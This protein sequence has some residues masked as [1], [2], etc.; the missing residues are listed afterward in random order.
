MAET[1]RLET[2]LKQIPLNQRWRIQDRKRLERA[3]QGQQ[4]VLLNLRHRHQRELLAAMEMEES[5][6]SGGKADRS[7]HLNE[8]AWRGSAPA[9]ANKI[10]YT[11]CTD[12]GKVLEKM[13]DASVMICP[14][15]GTS[16]R[17]LPT[18]REGLAFNEDVE[19]VNSYQKKNHLQELLNSVQGRETAPIPKNV[20]EDIQSELYKQGIVCSKDITRNKLYD[21]LKK[22]KMRR[23]YKNQTSI[24]TQLTGIKPKRML[25]YEEDQINLMFGVLQKVYEKHIPEGR[26]NFL[27]YPYV[28]YKLCELLGMCWIKPYFKLLKG[29]TVLHKQ[30]SV[31]KK[32]CAD[33]GWVYIPTI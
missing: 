2:Q 22:L 8:I 19:F 27:S 17:Y 15:C 1:L 12:C 23:Y 6:R 29:N 10:E 28:L 30:D 24:L 21:V 14:S 9:E 4:Q 25:S 5:R 16:T 3:I 26:I 13:V 31:W 32:I 18:T 20:I 11:N 33:I 7:H